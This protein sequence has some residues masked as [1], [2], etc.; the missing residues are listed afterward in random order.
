MNRSHAPFFALLCAAAFMAL[1]VAVA[2]GATNS[3]DTVAVGLFRTPTDAAMLIGPP[4]LHEVG[5]DLTAL[6]STVVLGAMTLAVVVLF[7]LRRLWRLAFFT[8]AC[9]AGGAAVSFS[10]KVLVDRPRPDLSAVAQV[11]TASFPSGHAALSAVTFLTLGILL[12]RAEPIYSL[13]RYYLALAGV[14]TFIVGASRLY[15]GLHYP[16]DI[17][18]GW[19]VGGAWC[20]LCLAIL[21]LTTPKGA[22]I[23]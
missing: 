20:A 6:G 17:L 1:W 5:R 14:A 23:P 11:F 12:A 8:F 7:L 9:V 4:W 16:S 3:L 15:L 21:D 22:S 18:A 2:L 10:L 19:L 13:R